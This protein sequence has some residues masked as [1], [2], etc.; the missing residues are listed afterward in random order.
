[1][2]LLLILSTQKL[3][4][5]RFI[6]MTL[7]SVFAKFLVTFSYRVCVFQLICIDTEW[8]FPFHRKFSFFWPLSQVH[9]LRSY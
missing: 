9:A 4:Q 5:T 3:L 6:Y 2:L 7:L 1:M 8:S